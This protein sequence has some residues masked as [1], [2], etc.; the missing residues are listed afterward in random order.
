[1]IL[2][3]GDIFVLPSLWEGLPIAL[4]EAMSMGKAIIASDVDGSNEVVK[5]GYN[6][7]LVKPGDK[8]GLAD[9]IVE[10]SL[11][12]QVRNQYQMNAVLTVKEKFNAKLMTKQVE[13]VYVEI[14][15]NKISNFSNIPHGI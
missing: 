7:K 3:V 8:I 10:L 13:H 2:A 5:D 1:D 11:S 12:A 9:A 15:S 4:L 14:L 6:G